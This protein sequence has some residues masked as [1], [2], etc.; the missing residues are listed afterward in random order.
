MRDDPQTIAASLV[1]EL[2]LEGAKSAALSAALKAQG[3]GDNYALSLWREV[4]WI[5]ATWSE[6][7]TEQFV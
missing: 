3:E 2:G 1:Q 7:E 5:L 4:K 6:P